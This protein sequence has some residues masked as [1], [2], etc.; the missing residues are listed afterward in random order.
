MNVGRFLSVDPLAKDFAGWSA[1]NYVLGNPVIFVDPDGRAP[2]WIYDQQE[3]GSYKRREGIAN[4]GGEN[5]HTYINN[6]GTTMY[7][8]IKKG[9][10]V[11]VD[12]N[13]M[14]AKTH[15]YKN[16][17]GLLAKIADLIPS[18]GNA[19]QS[20]S[21]QENVGE[22]VT[23]MSNTGLKSQGAIGTANGKTSTSI[24]MTDEILTAGA[25]NIGGFARDIGQP[26]NLIN[27]VGDIKKKADGIKESFNDPSF[28][29]NNGV[30]DTV[31]IEDRPYL[32]TE[33]TKNHTK[34][35]PLEK[36][37]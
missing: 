16:R 9:T 28:P 25:G 7:H 18:E 29:S 1:Y 27:R 12:Q 11:T 21:D 33:V 8:D 15:E 23:L 32:R 4:D 19:T 31:E 3:D 24:I 10:F 2:D 34:F 13:K 17:K 14:N 6:N 5:F 26:L 37:N 30:P 35:E 20:G 36:E 22:G